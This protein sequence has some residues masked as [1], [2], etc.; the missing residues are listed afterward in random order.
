MIAWNE[1]QSG[2]GGLVT[3]AVS[4][5]PS[6]F[7]NRCTIHGNR[8][9]DPGGIDPLGGGVL[10]KAGNLTIR[11]TIVSSNVGGG[12]VV[13]HVVPASEID[14]DYC[15]VWGNAPDDY[16]GCT[17]GAHSISG[18]PL[19]CQDAD[20]PPWYC[21]FAHSPC[22]G[23][24]QGGEDIGAGWVACFAEE[25]V[26][27]YDNFSDQADDGWVVEEEHPGQ[28]GVEA[29]EYSLNSLST[30]ARSYVADLDVDHLEF[31]VWFEPM[32]IQMGGETHTRWR[33]RPEDESWYELVLKTEEQRG[34]LLRYENGLICIM[35]EFDCPLY[36]GVWHRLTI[37]S[38]GSL[39]DGTLEIPFGLIIPLFH[40]DD[41]VPLPAG[42]VGL[43]VA[44]ASAPGLRGAQH[45]HFDRVMVRRVP[46]PGG[47]AETP[48]GAWSVETPL[49]L[50]SPNP[51]SGA[52][53]FRLRAPANAW[54]ELF[55]AQGR[56][57]RTLR[58]GSGAAGEGEIF[59]IG[60]DGRDRSGHPVGSGVYAWRLRTDAA[61]TKAVA[62][63]RLILLR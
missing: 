50:V 11:S 31:T 46:D 42:T 10:A 54:M 8:V 44:W 18:D 29:G 53:S 35:A 27:F 51:S 15:D 5:T 24:G 34:T 59:T 62:E 2:G 13:A 32:D 55:D 52:V 30:A 9:L 16:F 41:P 7:M 57:V 63:G 23:S 56:W 22:N 26:V 28:V 36:A 6:L 39:L 17:A 12:L 45:T 48:G 61:V 49:V 58:W 20:V 3:D 33:M 38:A 47:V 40:L 14:S 60:W 37:T 1:A 21:L 19:F 25:D 4:M 43:G